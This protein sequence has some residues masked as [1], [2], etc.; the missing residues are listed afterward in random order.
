MEQGKG[1]LNNIANAS[2]TM[3]GSF[4]RSGALRPLVTL[5][6]DSGVEQGRGI[7]AGSQGWE[8]CVDV[9]TKQPGGSIG[10][11]KSRFQAAIQDTRAAMSQ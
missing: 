4:V 10:G 5:G 1:R 6:R 3:E 11:T 9:Y 2:C 8:A 7:E